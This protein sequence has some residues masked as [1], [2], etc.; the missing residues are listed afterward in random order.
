[1]ALAVVFDPR[2]ALHVTGAGHPE[3][4][5]RLG[6]F[7]E[8]LESGGAARALFSSPAPASESDVLAVHDAGYLSVVERTVSAIPPGS[9][10]ELPTGDTVVGGE[11]LDVALLAA[12]GALAA[13]SAAKAGVPSLAVLRPPGHHAEPAR[14]MGFCVFNN[15]AVA[16]QAAR[17]SGDRVLIVDFDYHHGNGTQAWVE[18]AVDDG[19]PALG[20]VSTHAS[21]AYPGTGAFTESFVRDSGF[22]VD[23]PLP[24]DTQT[25][26]F[27][28]VWSSL[29]PALA[30]RLRP[31]VILVSAGFD[32][33]AGDP[34]AV[35]P[36][37][38]RAVDSLCGLLGMVALE[39]RAALAMILEGGYSLENLR[40]SGR[41]VAAD[42][43]SRSSEV[44]VPA[45]ALPS[46]PRLRAMVSEVLR[47]VGV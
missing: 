37:S 38:P 1:M 16:A 25:D 30:A 17:V 35:L 10:A 12:G 43:G 22:V 33:L 42:F 34:I 20:F 5:A 18:R 19:L 8:G 27:V 3:R 32:F 9:L 31:S 36:V 26:D 4:S 13:L 46:H 11:S 23:V 45:G 44:A 41:A 40:A 47:W 6:A 14:G 24:L 29:L 7:L 39:H 15:I 28:A 21:P 2:Y